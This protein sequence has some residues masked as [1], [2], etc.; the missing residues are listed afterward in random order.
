MSQRNRGP[1][2]R[3]ERIRVTINSGFTTA[4]VFLGLHDAVGDAK[5]LVRILIDGNITWKHL[6]NA[7][8]SCGWKVAVHPNN[9]DVA[10]KLTG[11]AAGEAEVTTAEIAGGTFGTIGEASSTVFIQM[12][13]RD[14]KA[15]R[16]LKGSDHLK[17][18]LQATDAN[19]L[20]RMNAVVYMWFKE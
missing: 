12:F 7:N 18:A 15:M 19:A 1:K 8:S 17:L 16:K 2:R 3:I 9:A 14:I 10:G 4:G 5:T 20:F 6:V 13:Q 11:G